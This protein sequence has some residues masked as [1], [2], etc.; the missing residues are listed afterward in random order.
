MLKQSS[1]VVQFRNSKLVV[2]DSECP[3][4]VATDRLMLRAEPTRCQD[5]RSQGVV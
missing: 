3:R 4:I 5:A 1:G 2:T